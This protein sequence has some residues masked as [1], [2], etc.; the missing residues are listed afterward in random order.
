MLLGGQGGGPDR[1]P[2]VLHEEVLDYACAQDDAYEE[3]VV[4]ETLKDVVLLGSQ[5]SGIDLVKD[6]HE[7]ESVE[8]KGVVL[9]LLGGSEGAVD[10]IDDEEGHA[11][12]V[13]VP[14]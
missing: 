10:G 4:E 8:D 5:L 7:D 13:G 1:D 11:G 12:F 3:E 2:S 9:G 6:L 14:E